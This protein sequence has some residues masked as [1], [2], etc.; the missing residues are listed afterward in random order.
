VFSATSAYNSSVHFSLF[1]EK[2]PCRSMTTLQHLLEQGT[3]SFLKNAFT[4]RSS[5][6]THRVWL[7]FQWSL[8]PL[9]LE[10]D[11]CFRRSWVSL[12]E[13]LLFFGDRKRISSPHPFMHFHTKPQLRSFKYRCS[14][15]LIPPKK[16][17]PL[18]LLALSLTLKSGAVASL[19]L[20]TFQVLPS[21]GP[22]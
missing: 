8:R 5:C 12:F 1:Q 17:S 22:L 20:I 18:C 6:P 7:P 3:Q 19:S 4:V 21:H 10:S 16:P 2:R 11:I 9:F 14:N 15:G 13:A